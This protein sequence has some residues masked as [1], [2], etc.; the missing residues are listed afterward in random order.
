MKSACE[1]IDGYLCRLFVMSVSLPKLCIP[2][3]EITNPRANPVVWAVRL[4]STNT[5][6]QFVLL[7]PGTILYF[8]LLETRLLVLSKVSFLQ[9]DTLI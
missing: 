6:G 8:T 3:E 5:W 1:I 9:F 7:C 2:F 4:A